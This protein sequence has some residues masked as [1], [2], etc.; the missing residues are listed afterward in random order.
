MTY[1]KNVVVRQ[2]LVTDI[3]QQLKRDANFLRWMAR[4]YGPLNPD[5]AAAFTT[6][7]EM[8]LQLRADI[9]AGDYDADP[10]EL[11]TEEEAP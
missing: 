2:V 4:R 1:P 9:V 10:A 3:S 6:G 7:A 11:F 8:M 5:Q